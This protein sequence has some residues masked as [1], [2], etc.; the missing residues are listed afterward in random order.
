MSGTTCHHFDRQILQPM[1]SRMSSVRPLSILLG[2]N[3]SAMEGRAAPMMSA[4]PDL[5]ICTISSGL[6]TRPTLTTGTFAAF[7]ASLIQGSM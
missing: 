3:G 4:W 1:H 7:L 5:I 6:V 2:R